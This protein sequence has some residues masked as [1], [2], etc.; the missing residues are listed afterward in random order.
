MTFVA[1]PITKD[2]GKN[3]VLQA[4]VVFTQHHQR[5]ELGA[6]GR[7]FVANDKDNGWNQS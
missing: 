2:V 1:I 3:V 4:C 6:G 5:E 7:V